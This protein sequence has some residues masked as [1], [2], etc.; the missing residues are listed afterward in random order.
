MTRRAAFA[1]ALLLALTL[2]VTYAGTRWPGR[3]A[4]PPATPIVGEPAVETRLERPERLLANGARWWVWIDDVPPPTFP[5]TEPPADAVGLDALAPRTDRF[6]ERQVSFVD[7]TGDAA[8][9]GAWIADVPAPIVA[10]GSATNAA[11]AEDRQRSRDRRARDGREASASPILVYPAAAPSEG[12]AYTDDAP[13]GGIR[14]LYAC[15]RFEVA[16]PTE[17]VGLHL[18][19]QFATGVVWWLN[20]QELARHHVRPGGE[21]HGRFSG[22]WWLPDHMFQMMYGRWQ[23]SWMGLDPGLLRRGPNMLCAAVWKRPTAGQRALFVDAFLDGYGAAGFTKSPWLQRVEAE[24][25]TV[26]FET[27]VP[28]WGYVEYGLDGD[29]LLHVATTPQVAGTLHE[30]ALTGLQ[31]NA[32]Y[33]YRARAVG[34]G[35]VA[36]ADVHMVAEEGTFMTAALPGTPY[37]FIVY[38][39]NRTNPDIHASVVARILADADEHDAR[40]IVHTGD[41]VTNASPWE[42]WQREFFEPALPMLHSLPI[43]TSLGN[44]EGNHESYY[45]YMSLPGNEAWYSFRYGDAEFFALNSSLPFDPESEQYRFIDDA[46]AASTA[47][48]QIVFFHHPPWACTPARKPGN[49]EMQQWLVPLFE[50]RGADLVLLG[51]DHLYGRTA[52]RNGVLYVISGGGGAPAYPAEPDEINEVCLREFHYCRVAVSAVMLALEAITADGR[53]I[54]SIALSR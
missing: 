33:R 48:W 35:P 29:E 23:R 2:G 45:T 4:D 19:G 8:F 50:A 20:G 21:E 25:I 14:N 22:H 30:V 47:A 37:S 42:E 13:E 6:A 24:A 17:F 39:D 3:I 38:G 11:M 16:D 54:D 5:L 32:R 41:L 49:L 46:L 40:F 7:D 31:P 1:A 27:T 53:L 10:R 28:A 44:H 34:A 15:T 12:L 26:M 51:H 52:V 9:P 36:G 18:E 43:Y